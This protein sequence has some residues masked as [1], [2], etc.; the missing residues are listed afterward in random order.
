[1]V[2]VV[3]S[4][5]KSGKS[6]QKEFQDISP[7]N[8]KIVKD[9]IKGELLDMTGYEF[10][11]TGG[12]DAAGFPMRSDVTGTLKKKIL[13]VKGVGIKRKRHG[14][15]QRKT[16]AG[17]TIYAKTAQINLKVLKEGKES[18]EPKTE[19]KPED[20]PKAEEKA[21]APK[22]EAKVEEKKA[23]EKPA[24]VPKEEAKPEEKKPEEK[25]AEAPKE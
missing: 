5:P 4:D 16:V 19:A 1:M 11:I 8:G 17:N 3:I 24:E 10:Q 9:V 20:A 6:Y 14:Q 12:S 15:R 7:F 2:K 22:E 23:E 25:P 13:A 21:E 18:L